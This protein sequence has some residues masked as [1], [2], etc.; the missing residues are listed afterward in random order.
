[1]E[2]KHGHTFRLAKPSTIQ[3]TESTRTAETVYTK[4]HL[5][6]GFNCPPLSRNTAQCKRYISLFKEK[7]MTVW[8]SVME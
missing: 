3:C 8:Q 1:M 7:R 2:T 4:K 5:A 6:V